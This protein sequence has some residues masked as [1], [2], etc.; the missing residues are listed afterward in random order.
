MCTVKIM[1][2]KGGKKV[3][4]TTEQ[5]TVERTYDSRE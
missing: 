1:K 2:R 5:G 4:Y 3:Q